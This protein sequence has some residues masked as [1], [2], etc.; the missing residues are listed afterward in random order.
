MLDP[1]PQPVLDEKALEKR[2][3]E[4]VAEWREAVQ[5]FSTFK[6]RYDHPLY[7]EIIALGWPAVP[8]LMREL[9]RDLKDNE[10]PHNWFPALRGI[11]G[12]DPLNRKDCPESPL[13]MAKLWLIW[14]Q[15]RH[16]EWSSK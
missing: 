8:L 16:I 13:E 4:L 2:F 11:T 14:A 7:Q 1:N 10:G 6:L 12:E 15:K 5:W 3:N 9:E